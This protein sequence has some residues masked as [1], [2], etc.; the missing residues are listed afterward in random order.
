LRALESPTKGAVNQ[1][2]LDDDSDTS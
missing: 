2:T 1:R